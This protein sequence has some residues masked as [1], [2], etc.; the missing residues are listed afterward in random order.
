M[1]FAELGQKIGQK[2]DNGLNKA[3]ETTRNF[4]TKHPYTT[5]AIVCVAGSTAAQALEPERMNEKRAERKFL[6]DVN[7]G[8]KRDMKNLHPGEKLVVS[9]HIEKI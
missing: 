8:V 4:V 6:K 2:M 7:K 1:K 5:I 3:K 9:G